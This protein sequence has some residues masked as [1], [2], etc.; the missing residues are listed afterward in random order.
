MSGPMTSMNE[1]LISRSAYLGKISII[2]LRQ[3]G[4]TVNPI[5][6]ITGQVGQMAARRA[7]IARMTIAKR[8]PASSGIVQGASDHRSPD[9]IAIEAAKRGAA[10]VLGNF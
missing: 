6:A 7:P 8:Q 9:A 2:V 10:A 1:M 3:N 5:S 4:S